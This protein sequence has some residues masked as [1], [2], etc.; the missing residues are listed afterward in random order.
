M[1]II[2]VSADKHLGFFSI[3]LRLKI[4]VTTVKLTYRFMFI[5]TFVIEVRT[6]L[7]I[8]EPELLAAFTQW[9][10]DLTKFIDAIE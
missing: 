2:A 10:F 6:K 7:Y 3:N 8:N 5:E 9:V 4:N 1:I